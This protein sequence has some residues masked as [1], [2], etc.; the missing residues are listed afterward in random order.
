[1]SMSLQNKKRAV[2]LHFNLIETKKAKCNICSN[3]LFYK[4]SAIS[5]LRKHLTV[6]HPIVCKEA[7]ESGKKRICESHYSEGSADEDSQISSS[8]SVASVNFI[9]VYF[10][11]WM[12]N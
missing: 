2:W 8:S 4:G 3:V 10:R 12:N 9:L 1:M 11:L 7:L 5:N 6:K